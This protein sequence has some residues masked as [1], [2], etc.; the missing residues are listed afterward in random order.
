ML[1]SWPTVPPT[2]VSALQTFGSMSNATNPDLTAFKARGGKLVQ[3]HGWADP[4]VPSLSAVNYYNSVVALEKQNQ[5]DQQSALAETQSYYRLFMAPGMGHCRG[6]PG[7]SLFGE[8]GGAGPASSDMFSALEAWVEHGA[9]PAQVIAH[10][11]LN[12]FTRPLCPYPQNA[13]YVGTGSTSDAAN[14]VCRGR[15]PQRR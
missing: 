15:V 13:V 4:L 6:G 3:Y 5:P 11:T 7:L 1:N 12:S 9:P 10:D 14:F 2:L 8:N